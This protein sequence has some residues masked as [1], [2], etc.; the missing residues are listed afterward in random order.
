[1]GGKS[2]LRE[3]PGFKQTVLELESE[4]GFKDLFDY[5]NI[6]G[7]FNKESEVEYYGQVYKFTVKN[8]KLSIEKYS[9]ELYEMPKIMYIPSERNFISALMS[10]RTVE[11]LPPALFTLLEEYYKACVFLESEAF[12]LP[13]Q[14]VYFSYEDITKTAY[15]SDK[16]KTYRLPLY[17]AAS[18][19]Q[20]IAPLSLVSSYLANSISQELSQKNNRL[21]LEYTE[22]VLLN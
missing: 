3:T 1:M 11:G 15:I 18:G 14:N 12:E 13:L 2:L 19:V 10:P 17:Q 4:K 21:S 6:T 22:K 20:S 5:H 9:Y 16:E 8:K 7:Y